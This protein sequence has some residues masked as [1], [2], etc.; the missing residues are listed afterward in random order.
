MNDFQ[1]IRDMILNLVV[2]TPSFARTLSFPSAN[3][4]EGLLAS[5]ITGY[6]FSIGIYYVFNWMRHTIQ[7]QP[8]AIKGTWQYER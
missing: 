6:I 7:E 5:F 2:V 8:V 4:P 3:S 1:M